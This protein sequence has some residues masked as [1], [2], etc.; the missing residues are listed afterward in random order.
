MAKVT[1]T[2]LCV[3]FLFVANIA[4]GDNEF[5]DEARDMVWAN[6]TNWTNTITGNNTF[7]E[8]ENTIVGAGLTAILNTTTGLDAFDDLNDLA[9]RLFSS[10]CGY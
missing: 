1:K 4:V 2:L 9:P 7:T 8:G 3:A 10:I 6:A 5:D